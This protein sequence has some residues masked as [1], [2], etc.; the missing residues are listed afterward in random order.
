MQANSRY[1]DAV[2]HGDLASA[3]RTVLA[4]T[5]TDDQ[6]IEPRPLHTFTEQISRGRDFELLSDA[7]YLNFYT[8]RSP[9]TRAVHAFLDE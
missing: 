9:L 2:K 5:C 8:E 6:Y 3:A 4:M 1:D 7:G